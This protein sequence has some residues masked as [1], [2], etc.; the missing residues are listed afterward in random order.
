M[1]SVFQRVIVIVLVAAMA[2]TGGGCRKGGGESGTEA[3]AKRQRALIQAPAVGDCYAAELTYFSTGDFDQH[4]RI[5]GLMKIAA[6]DGDMLVLVT[7][8]GGSPE[9]AVALEDLRNPEAIAFDESERI[10]ISRRELQAAFEAGHIFAAR[11][12]S[13]R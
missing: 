3:D 13:P 6:V 9:R 10:R 5:F 2:M 8:D 7:E 4:E 1:L 12:W 11:R